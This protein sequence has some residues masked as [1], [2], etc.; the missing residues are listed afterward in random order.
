MKQIIK[1]FNNL[2]KRTIFKVQNKTNN[3]FNISSF[4]KYLITFI[5]SL[6]VYLFYLL[7]PIL[8]DKTW[9]Q[10][11]IE[12]K[13]RDE[14]RI[15]LSTSADITYRIL[16][17]PHFLIKDSKIIVNEDEKIK[18]IAEIKDFKI[19]LSQKSFFDKEKMTI[20]KIVI[21]DA[22]FSILRSDFKLLNKFT[23][24]KFS[25]KEI[26]I[27]NSNIFFRDNLGEIISIIKV[28][29]TTLFFDDKKISNFINLKGEVFNIPFNF[30]FNYH[31]NSTKYK[32]INFSSKPLQLNIYNKSIIKNSITSGVNIISLLN[33][34]INTRYNIKKKLIIFKSD[35]I[36]LNNSQIN[37]DGEISI[38]PFDLKLN[39]NLNNH[40]ISNL[41]KI[42][43][44]LIQL[45]QSELLFNENISL[46]TT[47]IS[48]SNAKNEFFNNARIN[49]D[50]INGKINFNKTKFINYNIGTLELS[51]SDLFLKNNELVFNSDI[52]INIKNSKNLFSFLNTKKS[53]RKDFK[54]IL[55][56]LDYNFLS[57]KIK[58]N[59]LKIDNKD[60]S[61]QFLTII[62]GFNDNDIKNLIK[63]RRLLNELLKVYAG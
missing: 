19:F 50:I 37:Y 60:V 51:N 38:N 52:L 57:N 9:V 28:D 1:N 18:S 59:S 26:K 36:R 45:A 29:K 44:I 22:N 63:S 17:A 43:P 30:D 7:I 13:L 10:A 48:K 31:N 27:N 42:N 2:V 4:N 16:P 56:N 39:V 33:S 47:I 40:K 23:S 34:T 58:F 55:I 12:T 5:A 3:N 14:F 25:N 46:N 49:F 35:N 54:N 53:S 11:S 8:Y 62:D 41:F 32:E 21:N 6:F 20:N 15:N 24:K 61:N